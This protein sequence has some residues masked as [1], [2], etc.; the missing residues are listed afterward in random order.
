MFISISMTAPPT[1]V[2]LAS[3]FRCCKVARL[4]GLSYQGGGKKI[5]RSYASSLCNRKELLFVFFS[6]FVLLVDSFFL[7]PGFLYIYIVYIKF[8]LSLVTLICSYD[9]ITYLCQCLSALLF[10]K[11]SLLFISFRHLVEV[12]SF[13]IFW[14]GFEQGRIPSLEFGPRSLL[15]FLVFQVFIALLRVRGLQVIV[16]GVMLHAFPFCLL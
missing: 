2:L 10:K 1:G 16:F 12:M 15:V 8:L 11:M 4:R 6:C 3:N 7:F 5:L 14:D 9:D 13:V